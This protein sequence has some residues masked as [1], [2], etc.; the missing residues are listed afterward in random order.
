MA[1]FHLSSAIIG[2]QTAPFSSKLGWRI[3]VLNVSFSKIKY[4][5]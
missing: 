1:G 5:P 4:I 3:G 2:K